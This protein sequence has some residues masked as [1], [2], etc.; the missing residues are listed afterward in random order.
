MN[1]S[2]PKTGSRDVPPRSLILSV[3]GLHR[4]AL[5]TALG[6]LALTAALRL[7]VPFLSMYF[8][9]R[10]I[11]QGQPSLVVRFSG[12][13][14][15][16]A[17]IFA[18]T[19]YLRVVYFARLSRTLYSQAQMMLL[20]HVQRLPLP[21]FKTRDTGYILSRFVDDCSML[22][23]FIIDVLLTSVHQCAVLCFGVAGVF[24]INS[25]LALASM[26]ILPGVI[27]LNVIDE[28]NTRNT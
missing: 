18:V 19:E 3:V 9:D 1:T 27:V 22:S 23:S 6:L 5:A 12:L 14:L 25:R 8:L 28:E 21:F 7:P 10:I 16:M 11:P 26:I 13:V 2:N 17:S 20:R 24:F 4:G 15:G